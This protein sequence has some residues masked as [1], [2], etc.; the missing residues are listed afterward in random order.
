MVPV[1]WYRFSVPVSGA[2]VIGIRVLN[3]EG[4]T[5]GTEKSSVAAETAA[6]LMP[7]SHLHAVSSKSASRQPEMIGCRR[8]N[9][10][11]VSRKVSYSVITAWGY[12]LYSPTVEHAPVRGWIQAWEWVDDDQV[13]IAVNSVTALDRRLRLLRLLWAT[14]KW[15]FWVVE[16]AVELVWRVP[17]GRARM[18][19]TWER[20]RRQLLQLLRWQLMATS[21][22][23]R[24]A[25]I[26]RRWG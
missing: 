15:V 3:I 21:T 26:C 19:W 14:R 2:C 18:E 1:F 10:W 17:A 11:Q 8:L 5:T 7:M 25:V 6:K 16:V 12:K 22:V 24:R 23:T 4:R 20:R 9:A 13:I